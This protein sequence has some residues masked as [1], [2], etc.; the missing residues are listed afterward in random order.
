M[1]ET[2]KLNPKKVG[3]FAACVFLLILM[4]IIK[5]VKSPKI[6]LNGDSTI[7][8]ELGEE[9]LEEGA[10]AKYGK[11]DITKKIKI[12]DNIDPEKTGKYYVTYT[13]EYKNKTSTLTR[14]VNV[15]DKIAPEMEIY[16]GNE[17]NIEQDSTYKEFGC[18]A[19]DN[20][21]G[22]ISQNITIS[23]N[24]NTSTLGS[25]TVQYTVKDSSGNEST[26]ERTVNVVKKGSSSVTNTRNTGVPILMY[27]KFY[28]KEKGESGQDNN[29]IEIHD[30]EEQLK[31]LVDNK[32][33]FPSWDELRSF[34]EGKTCLPKHSVIITVDDGDD[35]FFEKAIPVIQKYDVKVTAF[36]VTSWI[37]DKNILNKYEKSKIIFESHSHDLH[38][39]GSNGNGAFLTISHDEALNDVKT[40]KE[41]LGNATLFS[42][43]F[44]HYSDACEKVLQEAG[45][46]LAFTK[47]Y[48]RARPG[49]NPYE[50]GR[51]KI[52]KGISLDTF[53]QRVS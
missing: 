22:D 38:K 14:T 37:K 24:I 26:A 35:S 49:D 16:G 43:P 8:I 45:Y 30:F 28:D 27:H 36:V 47:E 9:Y 34:V 40:S 23:H 20:Y 7:D 18:F 12:T 11:K 3:A 4:L 19:K 29:Y 10:T 46:E 48:L 2:R 15:V 25:Y 31:Y 17:I 42:Y 52:E 5:G 6:T 41:F 50:I 53:I 13:A 21:D 33:Y 1:N 32:Y 39:Y 44:G 51:I